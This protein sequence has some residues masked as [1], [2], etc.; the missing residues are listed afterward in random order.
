MFEMVI[1]SKVAQ[2]HANECNYYFQIVLKTEGNK[3]QLVAVKI[4]IQ[5]SC[6]KSERKQI[7]L[8]SSDRMNKALINYAVENDSSPELIWGSLAG[9]VSFPNRREA[10]I[11]AGTPSLS[12]LQMLRLAQTTHDN[13]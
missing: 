8:M 12:L 5:W 3:C 10:S 6:F 1:V 13:R 11:L 2:L 7:R 9:S 4:I